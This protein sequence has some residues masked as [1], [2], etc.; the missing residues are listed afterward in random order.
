VIVRFRYYIEIK[1]LFA[2]SHYRK[3][4][5]YWIGTGTGNVAE[6]DPG[7]DAFLTPGSRILD[8]MAIFFRA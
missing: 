7:S 6:P 4:L 1:I 8:S 2:L 3:H 5:S